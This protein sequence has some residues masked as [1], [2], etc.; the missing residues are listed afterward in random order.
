MQAT[1]FNVESGYLEGIVRGFK[2][3]I[4]THTQYANLA[5]CETLEGPTSNPDFKLQ[6]AATDYGNFLQ[7]EPSPIA[8]ST[9]QEK[10][11]DK[12]VA[13]FAYLRAHA[14]EPLATF[15]DYLTYLI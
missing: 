15:L 9:I 3:G 5:Q 14:L 1:V 13:E 12:L 7:N 10:A 4:L 8:T 2:Q 11:R 6:L